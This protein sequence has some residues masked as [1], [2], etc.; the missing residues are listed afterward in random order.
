MAT[1][2]YPGRLG[3]GPQRIETPLGTVSATLHE[4]GTVTARERT[5]LSTVEGGRAGRSGRGPTC[6]RHRMGRQLVLLVPEPR[7]DLGLEKH[8][9][10]DIALP[11]HPLRTCG[12]RLDRCWWRRD[13]PRRVVGRRS[14]DRSPCGTGTS[15]KLACLAADGKHPPGQPWHQE[16][17]VNSA[18]APANLR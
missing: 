6:R 17:V 10:F 1:L 8:P 12:A 7:P 4:D 16:S 11:C 3:A 14:I 9:S 2:A 15:A 5:L 18:I 13:R